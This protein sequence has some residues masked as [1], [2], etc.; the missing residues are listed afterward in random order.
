MDY[1]KNMNVIEADDLYG[2]LLNIKNKLVVLRCLDPEITQD[3]ELIFGI[4][5]ISFELE[6]QLNSCISICNEAISRKE[7]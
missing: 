3:K 1:I 4:K 5:E 7:L 2:T 6:K